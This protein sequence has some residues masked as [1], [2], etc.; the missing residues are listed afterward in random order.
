MQEVFEE[1]LAR[2]QELRTRW[3]AKYHYTDWTV[4]D[5]DAW[6][7]MHT[8]VTRYGAIWCFDYDPIIGY[9]PN[10]SA[11]VRH[12]QNQYNNNE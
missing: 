3:S 12:R 9:C 7:K 5:D 4:T 1:L 2:T 10:F 8:R 11:Y 6:Y